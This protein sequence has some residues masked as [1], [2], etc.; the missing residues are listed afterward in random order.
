MKVTACWTLGENAE[1]YSKTENPL[2]IYHN[3]RKGDVTINLEKYEVFASDIKRVYT[4]DEDDELV[5]EFWDYVMDRFAKKYKDYDS[6]TCCGFAIL[7]VGYNYD[8]RFNLADEILSRPE[9]IKLGTP[10]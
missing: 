1:G 6:E 8:D 7:G 2:D 3:E 10:Y 5:D 9:D 4:E